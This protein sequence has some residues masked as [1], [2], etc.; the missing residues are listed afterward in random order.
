MVKFGKPNAQFLFGISTPNLGIYSPQTATLDAASRCAGKAVSSGPFS[1]GSYVPNERIRLVRNPNYRWG[2]AVLPNRSAAH[3]EA[4]TYNIVTNPTAV[5]DGLING[6]LQL[7][8]GIADQSLDQVA[9]AG[10]R[11]L[12]QAPA[13]TAWSFIINPRRGNIGDIAV[14]QAMN[15]AIDR[16]T[17]MVTQPTSIVS[18]AKGIFAPTH[19]FFADHSTALAYD[20]DKARDILDKAGWRVGSNGIR[21]K[22]G[23]RL[24]VN[25]ISYQT[26]VSFSSMME[27]I[28]QQLSEVGIDLTLSPITPNEER[29]RRTEG[30]FETRLSKFTG[31]DPVILA[32]L[33]A[34]ID[35]VIDRLLAEQGSTTDPAKRRK[36]VSELS[37]YIMQQAY[38]IPVYDQSSSIWW[39]P[40][41][42]NVTF[43]LGDLTMMTQVQLPR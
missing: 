24:R 36:A 34:G 22:D 3:V 30:N 33:V 42:L 5:A 9:T 14:R 10:M 11:H 4:V 18:P 23:R 12:E 41:L 39:R 6:R 29:Q 13:G 21:V 15:I 20:P 35:P 27:L 40:D 32:Q 17:L 19:P 28:K 38:I 43:D 25:V 26:A 31:A 2:P 37:D 8:Q 16:E 7:A 1:I